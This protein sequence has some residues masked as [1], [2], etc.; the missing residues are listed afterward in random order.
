MP[1]LVSAAARVSVVSHSQQAVVHSST[2]LLQRDG[3]NPLHGVDIKHVDSVLT[4]HR[5]VGGVVAWTKRNIILD[6]LCYTW[7]SFTSSFPASTTNKCRFITFILSDAQILLSILFYYLMTSYTVDRHML[8]AKTIHLSF[9]KINLCT[10]RPRWE[11]LATSAP[12]AVTCGPGS[13]HTLLWRWSTAAVPCW[14]SP[15]RR[16]RPGSAGGWRRGCG[17]RGGAGWQGTR[18]HGHCGSH[19][20]HRA[21]F[22][23]FIIIIW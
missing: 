11:Q 15:R 23:K 14:K 13:P 10:H 4:V 7:V 3:L 2:D 9:Y 5:Q 17:P 16:G 21:T 18:H 8:N 6:N 22:I 20:K 1:P 12:A 19:G